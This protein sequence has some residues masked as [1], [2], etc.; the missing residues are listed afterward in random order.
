MAAMAKV[1][2]LASL[3]TSFRLE[4]LRSLSRSRVR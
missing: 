2:E 4:S 3:E 1:A